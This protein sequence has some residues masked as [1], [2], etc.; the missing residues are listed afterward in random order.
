[1]QPRSQSG[2]RVQPQRPP[3]GSS[4]LKLRVRLAAFASGST[5][6]SPAGMH[7][8][9]RV[10]VTSPRDRAHNGGVDRLLRA[11]PEGKPLR[12]DHASFLLFFPVRAFLTPA[13][14]GPVHEELQKAGA[15]PA[16]DIALA[17]E[18][19]KRRRMRAAPQPQAASWTTAYPSGACSGPQSCRDVGG[20]VLCEK[21]ELVCSFSPI[22]AADFNAY[23]HQAEGTFGG[24]C[25]GQHH[26]QPGRDARLLP[27]GGRQ[28]GT[29]LLSLHRLF[30]TDPC[31]NSARDISRN[32][33]YVA[34]VCKC[35]PSRCGMRI[36]NTFQFEPML[37]TVSHSPLVKASE[38]RLRRL[39]R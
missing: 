30:S 10:G 23:D 31:I 14:R 19:E 25:V 33:A 29:A 13:D 7:V 12:H 38:C 24:A 37:A 17:C 22:A 36:L 8:C 39:R 5:I 11:M 1:M 2:L 27:G 35:L 28:P 32:I 15:R 21:S 34:N 26:R 6:D 16:E 4:A 18:R 3:S 9:S 20:T